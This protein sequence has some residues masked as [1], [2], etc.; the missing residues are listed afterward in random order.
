MAKTD[1]QLGFSWIDPQ[2]SRIAAAWIIALDTSVATTLPAYQEEPAIAIALSGERANDAAL[3][4]AQ[5]VGVSREV[6][7]TAV[8]NHLCK[9]NGVKPLATENKGDGNG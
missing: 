2:L 9:A 5:E 6:A 4:A 7:I 3:N 8:I 1:R